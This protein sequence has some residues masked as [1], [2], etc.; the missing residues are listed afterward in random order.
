MIHE[1]SL[2]ERLA[3][4]PAARRDFFRGLDAEELGQLEKDWRFWGRPEQQP[5]PG[6][7]QTWLLLTG[8]GWGKSATLGAWA[9]L[10]AGAQPGACGGIVARTAA[11]VRDV[12]VPA[13]IAWAKPRNPCLYLHHS[14]TIRWANGARALCFSSEQPNQIRGPNLSW[15][16]GDELATWK[17]IKDELGGTAWDNLQYA[18]RKSSAGIEPQIV[19]ATTPRPLD[20]IRKLTTD[21]Y[22][23]LTRGRMEENQANLSAPVVDMLRA[24]Y[25]GTRL[26]RQE[27]D[28]EL[29]DR[30]E[31][32]IV[33]PEMIAAAR[34]PCADPAEALRAIRRV[35]GGVGIDPAGSVTNRSDKTGI[36]P[37]FTDDSR[38]PHL[39]VLPPST[40]RYSPRGW[41][42]KAE[43]ERA[44]WDLE[45][46]VVERYGGDLAREVMLGAG[47]AGKL[48]DVAAAQGKHV[49]FE[50]LGGLYEQGRVHHVGPPEAFAE[51][52]DQVCA[53]TPEA[54]QGETSPDSADA[55]VWV[56]HRLGLFR[57]AREIRVS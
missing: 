51:L 17:Q 57:A 14:R 45:F 23:V 6:A 38:P 56:A 8:R 46:I 36:V 27:L 9:N 13:I 3:L 53:F 20:L 16:I 29:L 39:Y 40:G 12:L 24:R 33:S 7:W 32:A 26:G 10:R 28:G 47:V 37:A 41:A 34:I 15:A 19:V 4:D 22:A 48:Y 18:T 35:R 2:A 52:E 31:G 54:Y 1:S 55:L 42:L 11:D 25:G 21:T 43:H 30:Y 5:P 49:R 50:P 44:R